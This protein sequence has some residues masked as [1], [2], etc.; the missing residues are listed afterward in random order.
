MLLMLTS[1]NHVLIRFCSKTL[2]IISDRSGLQKKQL[3]I[4][5]SWKHQLLLTSELP[6]PGN[7]SSGLNQEMIGSVV[8]MSHQQQAAQIT[9]LKMSA[10]MHQF[11][12]HNDVSA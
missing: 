8:A 9:M 11:W 10:G 2:Q 1:S 3:S 12:C 4:I 7:L 5:S 6:L